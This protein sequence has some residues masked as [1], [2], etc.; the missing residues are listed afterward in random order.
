MKFRQDEESKNKVT[1]VESR[2][3]ADSALVFNVDSNRW[4]NRLNYL[5]KRIVQFL[6]EGFRLK[7]IAE[8]TMASITLWLAGLLARGHIT[9]LHSGHIP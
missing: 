5:Q 6:I 4:T 9:S 3:A 2:E 8:F 7:E 1:N